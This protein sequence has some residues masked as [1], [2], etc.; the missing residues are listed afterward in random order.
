MGDG[1][2]RAEWRPVERRAELEQSVVSLR[3]GPEEEIRVGAH[4]DGR[5]DAEAFDP[6]RELVDDVRE[7]LLAGDTL[8]DRKPAPGWV[9]GEEPV[10]DVLPDLDALDALVAVR[11][12]S[13]VRASNTMTG[14]VPGRRRTP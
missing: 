4:P 14:D 2:P 9:D 8:L 11:H 3:D 13:N 1:Q 10:A 5:V 7:R 6:T 12:A